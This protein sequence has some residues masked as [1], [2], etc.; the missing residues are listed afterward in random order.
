M[1]AQINLNKVTPTWRPKVWPWVRC[2]LLANFM[3]V[4]CNDNSELSGLELTGSCRILPGNYSKCTCRVPSPSPHCC[5]SW[6]P[7]LDAAYFTSAALRPLAAPQTCPEVWLMFA[8]VQS[9]LCCWSY[10]WRKP[11]LCAQLKSIILA[12]LRQM[13]EPTVFP[14][15]WPVNYLQMLQK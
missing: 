15:L 12:S 5:Q 6:V 9:N 8:K 3:L 7:N 11:V 10:Y 2:T 14:N 4:N 13:T 1:V